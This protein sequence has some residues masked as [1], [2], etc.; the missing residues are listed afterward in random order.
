MDICLYPATGTLVA[1]GGETTQRTTF[2]PA[3][4]SSYRTFAL[5]DLRGTKADL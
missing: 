5:T 4:V 1:E 3:R 2:V